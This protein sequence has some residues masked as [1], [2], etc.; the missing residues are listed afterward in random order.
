MLANLIDNRLESGKDEGW[1]KQEQH[2]KEVLEVIDHEE[3]AEIPWT[4]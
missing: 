4:R 3:E 2:V 1:A